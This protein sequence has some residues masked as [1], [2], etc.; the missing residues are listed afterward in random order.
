MFSVTKI[1]KLVKINHLPR[2]VF[3]HVSCKSNNVWAVITL[4]DSEGNIRTTIFGLPLVRYW[5]MRTPIDLPVSEQKQKL[6][7]GS[8]IKIIHNQN[9]KWT[10]IVSSADSSDIY[11]NSFACFVYLYIS[12]LYTFIYI[13]H[14]RVYSSQRP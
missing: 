3:T 5:F 2:S 11:H 12:L 14:I 9:K 10:L 6:C 1:Q 4:T 8:E 7:G 13:N